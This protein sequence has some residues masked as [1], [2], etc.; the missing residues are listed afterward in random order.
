MSEQDTSGNAAQAEAAP[1][2]TV[3]TTQDTGLSGDAAAVAEVVGSTAA[4][5]PNQDAQAVAEAVGTAGETA[6]WSFADGV[7]GQGDVPEWFKADKYKSVADQAKAYKDLESRF[8]SFTG[9]PEEYADVQLNEQLVEMGVELDKEDPMYQD[10]LEFAKSL[11]MNQEGFDKMIELYAMNQVAEQQ[12]IQDH[13]AEQIQQLGPQA[14]ARIN[15]IN[16]WA[17]R[18]LP[19]EMI[20]GL[21]EMATSASTV[22]T[23]ERLIAMSRPAQ[24]APSGEPVSGIT[25]GELREMQFETDKNGQRRIQTDPAFRAKFEELMNRFH[26]TENNVT[27]IGG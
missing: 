22:Q 21:Q 27:V 2:A 8:G 11:D 17:N 9:A 7:P 14:E 13:K 4:V 3:D 12:A 18:N 24:V 20:E 15:N 6:T 25:E 26:G 16:A 1:E 5:D 23:L 19:P 10:A